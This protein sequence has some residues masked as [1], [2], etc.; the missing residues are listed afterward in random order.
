[1][2]DFGKRAELPPRPVHP[3]RLAEK[4]RIETSILAV[5]FMIAWVSWLHVAR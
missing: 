4:W 3:H 1:M 5:C 2:M